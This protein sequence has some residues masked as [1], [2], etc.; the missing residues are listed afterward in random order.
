MQMEQLVAE[1]GWLRRLALALVKDEAAAD[2]LVQDTYDVA[3]TQAPTDGRPLKPWLARVLWNRVRMRSRS[4]RRRQAREHAFGEL[5]APPA[6]PDEIVSRLELQ[7]MLAGFVLEL[8]PA[9]RDVLLLHYFEGLTSTQIGTRLGISAGTVRWRLK[10]AI[11]ELRDRL[12]ERSPNRAWL[13][14]L[15]AFARHVPRAKVALL[16]KLIFAALIAVA[17]FGLILRSQVGDAQRA[18]APR[19][20]AARST[21]ART[22]PAP[23]EGRSPAGHAADARGPEL[24]FGAE[25]RR[26]EGQV[27]DD[28]MR[29]VADADVEVDCGYRDGGARTK[30][31]TNANGMFA[32]EIDPHCR[33]TLIA[34]KGTLRGTATWFELFNGR[35]NEIWLHRVSHAVV[36]VIDAETGAPIE[37][38]EVTTRQRFDEGVTVATGADGIAHIDAVVPSHVAVHD[39]HHVDAIDVVEDPRHPVASADRTG[40]TIAQYRADVPAEVHLE[41]R[42]KRG[43]AVSGSVVGVDGNPIAGAGVSLDGV[44][45]GKLR[46]A[47]AKTDA[48]G[49]FETIVPAAARYTLTAGREDQTNAGPLAID[50]PVEG[51]T[52]VVAHVVPRGEL[53]GTVVDLASRPVANAQVSIA[54]GSKRP[55]RTDASGR[56]ALANIDGIVD[57]IAQRGGEASAFHHLQVKPGERGDVTLQI[58]PTGISGIAVERDGT[59]VAGAQVWLNYCCDVSPDLV[60]GTGVTTDANGK[61]SFDVPRGDFVLSIKR[62]DDDDYEDEDNIKVT[63]GSRDVRIVVP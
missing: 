17:I 11:A 24:G 16:P 41:I 30:R 57:V 39:A 4:A 50:I 20:A 25:Q 44:A 54:D 9:Y 5:A 36:R 13:A 6:R 19:A 42:M 2:D 58:G 56:F 31:R 62:T 27:L 53:H 22:G 61:F 63:G 8:A 1:T 59:P 49:R 55:V 35:R 21:H 18:T 12:E 28:T 14:P 15:A 7:R 32:I 29:G 47:T 60:N 3:A 37:H 38:A 46:H 10:H 23:L 26:I 48:S 52:N 51:R 33:Y 45:S 40:I 43:I 34:T